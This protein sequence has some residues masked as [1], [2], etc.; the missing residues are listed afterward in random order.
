[1]VLNKCGKVGIGTIAPNATLQVNGGVSVGTRVQT[2]DYMMTNSDFAIFANAGVRSITIKLP[3]ASNTGQ[4]V[5]I[6]KIDSSKNKVTVERQSTDTIE[7]KTSETLASE[8]ASS[9]LIAGGNG[10]WYI[11]SNAT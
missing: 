9:T 10:F 11:L 3:S 1:M 4:V 5:H 7:G 6:K 8:F 2:S